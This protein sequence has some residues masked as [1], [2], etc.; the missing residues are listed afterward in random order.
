MRMTARHLFP[1]VVLTLLAAGLVASPARA[2]SDIANQVAIPYEM[3]R[4]DNGL[5][6]LV[7]T[8]HSVPTVLVGMWYGVG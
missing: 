8:D 1:I 5:T 4:L 3:F 7:H 2:D 6:V